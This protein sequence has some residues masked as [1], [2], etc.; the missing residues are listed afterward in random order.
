VIQAVDL[1][2]TPVVRLRTSPAWL[3]QQYRHR[4]GRVRLRYR[5][6]A[7]ER[8][9]F[10]QR[11]RIPPC[12]WAQKN[13]MIT[14]GPLKG[15]MYDPSF[16]PHMSGII[17]TFVLPYVR[18]LG[19]CKAPQTGSSVGAETCLA[20]LGDMD[21]GDAMVVYP[22]RETAGKRAKDYLKPMFE[23]S[24]RLR[25]LL[26][27]LA[28]DMASFRMK[29]QTMLVYMGWAHSIMSASNVSVKYLFLDE[30]DKYPE[31]ASKREASTIDL[32]KDRTLA[33]PFGA[34]IWWNSTPALGINPMTV[35]LE[36]AD[37]VFDF[38]PR[39]PDCGKH[40]FMR[41]EHIRW[42]EERDPETVENNSLARYVCQACGS[43]WDD[44]RRDLALQ[45]GEWFARQRDW[46][47]ERDAGRDYNHD[48][49]PREKYLEAERPGKVCF[50]SP[51]WISP[52]VSLSRIATAFLKGLRN[53]LAMRYFVNQHRAEG[54]IDYEQQR[55]ED[56][57]LRL[58]DDR[59]RRLVPAGNLVAGVV[60]GVDTQD[61]GFW[62]VILAIGWGLEQEVWQLDEGFVR[63][64]PALAQ[65]LWKEELQDSNGQIY[66]V[67]LTVQDAM[68]HRTSE[69]YDQV[70]AHPG[71]LIPYK[72]ASGRRPNPITFTK[73]DRYPGTNKPIPG[74]VLL[75]TC[76]SHHYKDDLAARLAVNPDDPGAW[77]M[78]S[79][80][81]EDVARQMC[82]EFVDERGLWEQPPNRAQH[83]WDASFLAL[84]AAD[85]LRLKFRKK[86]KIKEKPAAKKRPAVNPYTGTAAFFGG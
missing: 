76:D 72:G 36:A 65:V 40:V 56:Q 64:W 19:N 18:E 46:K 34:K 73:I 41:F 15:S 81:T 10:R 52:R 31:Q 28:D 4:T 17:D 86:P 23:G 5:Y 80:Y 51:S 43:E 69:V 74:G 58:R 71:R 44:R 39:C 61:N 68:G 2:K 16:M 37:A 47:K 85:I 22:D 50:H 54:W 3:P 79:E 77:H 29:L 38:F 6:T 20:Y 67:E 9:L 25:S 78:H 55:A 62:Y 24:P 32:F 27:G 8:R 66:P 21:P 59:P 82:V 1:H 83:A 42:G 63:T 75:H 12:K 48:S 84:I 30:C 14:Y 13:R 35:F 45:G 60:A 33:F 11:K 7:G 53:K 57:I 49:R 70:R 26:T